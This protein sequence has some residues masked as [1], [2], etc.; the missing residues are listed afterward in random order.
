LITFA[1]DTAVLFD[2]PVPATRA[3]LDRAQEFL[4]TREAAAERK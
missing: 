1:G 2:E 4:A 3:N